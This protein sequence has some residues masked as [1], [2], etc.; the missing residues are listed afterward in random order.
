M[1]NTV[2]LELL[3]DHVVHVKAPS[4]NIIWKPDGVVL[5]LRL[6]HPLHDRASPFLFIVKL[7][8]GQAIGVQVEHFN[9]TSERPSQLALSH[10]LIDWNAQRLGD[11]H[12]L[13]PIVEAHLGLDRLYSRMLLLVEV[14]LLLRPE[15]SRVLNLILMDPGLLRE[16][17]LLDLVMVHSVILVDLLRSHDMLA[18]P[19]A[20]VAAID[21]L[22]T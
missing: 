20:H 8:H 19:G 16:V 21:H 11:A 22:L 5:Q 17:L 1:P 7:L 14:A 10:V 12:A 2:K 6:L 15:H 18:V 3:P 13:E 4:S 9:I